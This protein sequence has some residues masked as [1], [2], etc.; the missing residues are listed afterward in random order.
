MMMQHFKVNVSSDD[1]YMVNKNR[2]NQPDEN[3]SINKASVIK[4]TTCMWHLAES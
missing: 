1:T 4:H 2:L 3:Q